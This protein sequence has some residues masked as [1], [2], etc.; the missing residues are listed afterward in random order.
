MI[1]ILKE[2]SSIQETVKYS[3][4]VAKVPEHSDVSVAAI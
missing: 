4:C 2:K 3:V 1:K